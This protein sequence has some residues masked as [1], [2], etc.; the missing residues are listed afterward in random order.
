MQLEW[1]KP[2]YY[3]YLAK[4]IQNSQCLT[5]FVWAKVSL[6][7]FRVSVVTFVLLPNLVAYYTSGKCP[8]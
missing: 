2:A 4:G 7:N 8:E 3:Y 5:L 1:S 6:R